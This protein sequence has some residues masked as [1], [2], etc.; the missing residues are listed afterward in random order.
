MACRPG[1][2]QLL[3]RVGNRYVVGLPGNPLAALV[4]SL[5][6]LE[7][8]VRALTGRPLTPLARAMM[9]SGVTSHHAMTRLVPVR[10]KG[11]QVKPVGKDR[12]GMLWGAA[13]ADAIAVVPPGWEA[14]EVGLLGLPV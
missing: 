8:V 11:A 2:P 12:P 13:L 9:S 14:G 10:L 7:P 5:T 1:H 3:A 4:A 6:L